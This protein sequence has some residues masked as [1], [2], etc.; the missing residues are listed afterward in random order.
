[1]SRSK[2]KYQQGYIKLFH[3]DH[4]KK[5]VGDASKIIYR[6]GWEKRFFK[7][8]INKKEVVALN[9]EEVVIQYVSPKDN[10]YHRYFMDFWFK[11]DKGKQF[12]VEVKPFA[13]TRRPE[14][15]PTKNGV[16]TAKRKQSYA[17]QMNTYLVNLSKWKYANI[18]AK[19]NNLTFL[20]LTD[21]TNNCSRNYM[22]FKLWTLDELGIK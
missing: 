6:S 9:M 17:T 12:I 11:T 3:E 13:Q 10:K 18:Y 20:I 7:Y 5:Y 16:L 19:K 14:L 2:P 4:I 1:M 21:D 15:K 8:L 22:N